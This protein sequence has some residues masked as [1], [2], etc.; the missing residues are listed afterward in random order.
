MVSWYPFSYLTFIA[1]RLKRNKQNSGWGEECYKECHDDENDMIERKMKEKINNFSGGKNRYS[2]YE[3]EAD[4][5]HKR[6]CVSSN[7]N[8][9]LKDQLDE[10]CQKYRMSNSIIRDFFKMRGNCM[11]TDFMNDMEQMKRHVSPSL[12]K[13]EKCLF[14]TNEVIAFNNFI[15]SGNCQN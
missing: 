12:N 10:L 2:K 5:K 3:T 7:H 11:D 6:K 8:I 13:C 9:E 15:K 14:N 4:N 1:E